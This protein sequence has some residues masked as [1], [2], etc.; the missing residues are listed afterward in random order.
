MID[1]ERK[2]SQNNKK[3]ILIE[4]NAIMK[5]L[6]ITDNSNEFV[7]LDSAPWQILNIF[8]QVS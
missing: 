6:L 8:Y 4:Y 7:R 3:E 5:Q 2:R 1:K